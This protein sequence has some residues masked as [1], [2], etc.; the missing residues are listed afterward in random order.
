[1]YNLLIIAMPSVSQNVIKMGF[2]L[3]KPCFHDV[4]ILP[5]LDKILDTNFLSNDL[6]EMTVEDLLARNP[7]RP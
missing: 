4:K 6:K 5:P 7:K 2:T 3:L 1:M